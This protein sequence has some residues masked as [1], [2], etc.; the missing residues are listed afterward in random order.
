M[1]FLKIN[2]PNINRLVWRRHNKLQIGIAAAIPAIPL[3]VPL[4]TVQFLRSCVVEFT[5]Y[6]SCVNYTASCF[7]WSLRSRISWQTTS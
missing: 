1:I 6:A 3:P 7:R 4:Q 5:C 2:C